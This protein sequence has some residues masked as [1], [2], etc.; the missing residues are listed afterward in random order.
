M[1]D[2]RSSDI[3]FCIFIQVDGARPDVIGQLVDAGEMR[4]ARRYITKPATST[5][6]TACLPN[7]SSS[8]FKEQR[9][10]C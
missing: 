10:F 5:G 1:R 4:N 3:E 2:S 6:A 8:K 7:Q 9:I